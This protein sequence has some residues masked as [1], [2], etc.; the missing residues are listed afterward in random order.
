M[1]K[2][3]QQKKKYS[4]SWGHGNYMGTENIKC[5]HSSGQ[6]KEFTGMIMW[7]FHESWI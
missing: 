3:F 6:E 5:G 4:V 2:L 7:N 1:N